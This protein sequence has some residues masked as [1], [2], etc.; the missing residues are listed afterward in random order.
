VE[1]ERRVGVPV[2]AIFTNG[3]TLRSLLVSPDLFFAGEKLLE[4]GVL[5]DRIPHRID[6]QLLKRNDFFPSRQRKSAV[7]DL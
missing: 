2:S 6:F 5:P 7:V 1:T 4:A 3:F